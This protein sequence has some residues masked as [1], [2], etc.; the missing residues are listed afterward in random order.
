M[1]AGKKTPDVFYIKDGSIFSTNT[2][3]GATRELAKLPPNGSVT[4]INADETLIAGTF[5]EGQG[6]A[7]NAYSGQSQQS[8]NRSISQR[9]EGR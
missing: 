6:P 7:N 5:T 4:T 3:S 1:D 9:A 2:E 8:R